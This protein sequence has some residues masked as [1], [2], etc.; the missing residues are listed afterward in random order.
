MLILERRGDRYV[1]LN[2]FN[3]PIPKEKSNI[4]EVDN[5]T[6]NK[7]NST[8]ENFIANVD[9]NTDGAFTAIVNNLTTDRSICIQN[10][11]NESICYQFG[12]H[13]SL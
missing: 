13:L 11:I 5:S 10:R 7:V 2:I 4:P 9:A 1:P 12:K 8:I 3:E 6:M